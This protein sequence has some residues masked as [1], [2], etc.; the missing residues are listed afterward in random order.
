MRIIQII[1]SL[2]VGGAE[3]M[4]V[5]YA[6]ALSAKIAFSGLV[7]TRKEGDL[8]TQLTPD[9]TYL[10]LN[11][12]GRFDIGAVLRLRDFCKTNHVTIVHAHG[13]SFFIA[14]LVRLACPEIQVIW[15]DHYG[16]SE[17][18][19]SRKATILKAASRFFS[20]IIAVNKQLKDWAEKE[21]LC[22]N[23]VYLP[24][25]TSYGNDIIPETALF[26][27]SGKRILCLANLRYQKNHAMLLSVAER[28]KSS[29]PDW[30]FHLVG[31]DFN[32]SYSNEIGEL[33]LQKKLDETVFLYG[34]RN[35]TVHII[36]QCDI[37]I[38]TSRSE[39]LPVALLEYGLFKKPVVVTSVGEIPLII[40]DGK[41]GFLVDSENTGQFYE[42]LVSLIENKQLRAEFGEALYKT[43]VE[44]HSGEAIISAYLNWIGT[45]KKA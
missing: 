12:K 24:N 31:K 23:V 29:H 5:N 19:A 33:I 25:F 41:N 15:H 22:R 30:S 3:R 28:L 13:T 35:D 42:S 17:F 11:K 1:D 7:A 36:D 45:L 37:A 32:D 43:V 14:F 21:L 44:K 4:A 27:Q 26:G 2:E 39:G 8:K 9:V 16:L 34:S 6:N 38:M 10:F 40:E 20:G 18:L